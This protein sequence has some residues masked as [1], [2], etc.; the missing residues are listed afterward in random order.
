MSSQYSS[1]LK[2]DRI[3]LGAWKSMYFLCDRGT[4]RA[5]KSVIIKPANNTP[6]NSY[7]LFFGFLIWNNHLSP[8]SCCLVF[9]C[10]H[11]WLILTS[12]WCYVTHLNVHLSVFCVLFS[13]QKQ[14]PRPHSYWESSVTGLNLKKKNQRE[15]ATVLSQM[16]GRFLTNIN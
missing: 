14:F 12:L 13:S 8:F 5:I 7:L 1:N 4:A 10:A 16:S 15:I 11:L 9:R 3:D 6:E 2:G